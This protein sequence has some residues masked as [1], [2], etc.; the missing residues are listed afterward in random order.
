MV[1]PTEIEKAQ[2]LLTAEKKERIERC[3]QRLE[4]LLKEERCSMTVSIE[5]KSLFLIPH[6]NVIALD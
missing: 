3:Q 1:K 5:L 2:A 4:A 6:L